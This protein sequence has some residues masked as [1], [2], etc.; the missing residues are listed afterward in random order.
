L[1]V[2]TVSPVAT[3]CHLHTL[4]YDTVQSGRSFAKFQTSHC[5]DLCKSGTHAPDYMTSHPKGQPSS[6]L[7]PRKPQISPVW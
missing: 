6:H 7:Q 2:N 4:T 1:P 5:K 3:Y